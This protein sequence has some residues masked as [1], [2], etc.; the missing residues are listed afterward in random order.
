MHISGLQLRVSD[1]TQSRLR[2]VEAWPQIANPQQEAAGSARLTFCPTTGVSPL[3]Q[4]DADALPAYWKFSM[5]TD[6]VDAT[7]ARLL[8]LGWQVSEPVQFLDIGYLCHTA[9]PDGL[10]IELLQRDFAPPRPRPIEHSPTLWFCG[11]DTLGLITLRIASVEPNLTFYQSVLGMKLLAVMDVD[12]GRPEPFTLYFLAFTEDNAPNGDPRSI[13]NREWLYH[14]PYTIMELQH[15]WP[16]EALPLRQL[17][18]PPVSMPG[19]SHVEIEASVVQ[20]IADRAQ[21]L[22]VRMAQGCRSHT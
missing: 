15:H 2:Y 6:A 17:W 3:S 21:S 20:P 22:G 11:A 18:H 9:D 13:D 4:A 8:Q 14:R 12:D 1:V 5:F 10:S 7:R 19:L 16:V